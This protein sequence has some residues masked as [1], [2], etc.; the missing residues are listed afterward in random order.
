VS[1]ARRAA[2]VAS[3]QAQAA[4][5]RARV[6]LD[7]DGDVW[8]GPDVRIR[9]DPDTTSRLRIDAG[10]VL[11][12]RCRINLRGGDIVIAPRATIRERVLLN[13][14]GQLAIGEDSIVSHAAVIHCAERVIIG[15]RVGV[16]EY[17]SIADSRHFHTDDGVRVFDNVRTAPVIIGADTWLCPKVTVTSGVRIG[18]RCVIASNVVVTK[19]VPDDGVLIGASTRVLERAPVRAGVAAEGLAS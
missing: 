8:I 10:A 2:L 5:Q 19:D 6:T 11:D 9:V 16:A 14:S 4:W 1:A 13:V 18:A 7:I 17:V 3:V 15:E 12:G